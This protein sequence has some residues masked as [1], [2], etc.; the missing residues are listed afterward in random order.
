LGTD[1]AD[2]VG[3]SPNARGRRTRAGLLAA[4]R[5]LL[6][7][8]G[9]GAL[10]MNAVAERA[11]VTRKAVYLHFANRG[12]LVTAVFEQ[13]ADEAG[14]RTSLTAVWHAADSVSAVDEWAAHLARYHPRMLAADRALNQVRDR[15]PDA[16]A[17]YQ[18]VLAGQ[19][20]NCRRLASWLAAEGRLAE[21]WTVASAR[22]MLY[23]LISS[24]V[25]GALTEERRWS[26]ARL[27]THLAAL[28]R[29]TFVTD[30]DGPVSPA[31]GVVPP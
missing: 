9:V 7:E 24:E 11:G 29:A 4:A 1:P 20:A 22:D 12:E 19:L 23:A 6:V 18:R 26:R 25:I 31:R 13:V 14:F 28:F 21:P 27:A 3:P 5:S 8:G 15:D 2:P 17:Y 16:A 10:T 30:R